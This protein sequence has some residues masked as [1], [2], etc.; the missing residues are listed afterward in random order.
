MH[1]VKKAKIP[2]FRHH[3]ASGRGFVQLGGKR[4]YL[5][6]FHEPATRQRYDRLIGYWIANGA[7]LPPA[8]GSDLTVGELCDAFEAWA[9]T[10]YQDSNEG[11]N[12][13]FALAPL[14]EM[15]ASTPARNFGPNDLAS[16]R[17]KLIEKDW[18]RNQVNRGASRVRR[19]FKWAVGRQL[20]PETVHR[21]LACVDPLR[22][23]ESKLRET[24]AVG[25]VPI[26]H[27]D[28][29]K[30]FVSRQVW[31]IIQ[32]QLRTA[33]RAGE[34]AMMRAVDLDT[35]GA[36]WKYTPEHHKT[37]HHGKTR[38]I[39][40]GPVAQ[41]V[42]KPFLVGRSI[43]AR[44]FSPAEA[45]AERL[46]ELH[47]KRIEKGTPLSCGNGV[48]K[49]RK[50]NPKRKPGT[51]YTTG[52]YAR[53]IGRACK[54]TKVPHWHPHQLRHLAADLIEREFGIEAARVILGHS[55]IKMTAVYSSLDKAK[56]VECLSKIG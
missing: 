14:R 49:S 10:R 50:R 21:A 38:A 31:A 44:L 5:G 8:P 7:T 47:K 28:A 52:A 22:R 24:A 45:E 4:R 18:C 36:I 23:G 2:S 39:Y 1:A 25:P 29:I 54:A 40:L 11:T 55:T 37:E 26:E 43:D 12:Y 20:V 30:P 41:E 13:K 46:E 35:S 9:A 15:Y 42:V 48:G 51:M 53:A 16:V 33:A 27:V 3:K 56:A 19:V 17:Q 34:I 32:L 6:P